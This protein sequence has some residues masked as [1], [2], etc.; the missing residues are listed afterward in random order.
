MLQV[1]CLILFTV[2]VVV[3]GQLTSDQKYPLEAV[4]IVESGDGKVKGFMEFIQ[5]T[6]GGPVTMKLHFRNLTPGLH[7]FHI[8]ENSIKS[9]CLSAGSHFN[10]NH[11]SFAIYEGILNV[12]NIP[13]LCRMPITASPMSSV[14]IRGTWATLWRTKTAQW[15]RS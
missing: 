5:S 4:A 13:L 12:D 1:N 3:S 2:V 9:G 11:V 7:G 6:P 14:D 8:H 10:P 15:R